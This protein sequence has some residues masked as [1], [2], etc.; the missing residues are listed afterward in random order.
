MRSCLLVSF[1][2]ASG[3]FLLLLSA[4]C[5]QAQCGPNV[6]SF[7]DVGVVANNPFHAEVTRTTTGP[8]DVNAIQGRTIRKWS[9]A[10]VRDASER[11]ESLENSSVTPNPMREAQSRG[12]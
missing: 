9:S 12:T 7:G 6:V 5:S 8:T 3:C 1:A 4:P 11:K 2:L 10:T